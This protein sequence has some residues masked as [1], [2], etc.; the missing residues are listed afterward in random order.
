MKLGEKRT[1]VKDVLLAIKSILLASS[2]ALPR[3]LKTHGGRLM[4]L[5]AVA[6]NYNAALSRKF[7]TV[8]FSL[9]ARIGIEI[10]SWP[11]HYESWN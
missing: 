7:I 10:I 9:L 1:L 6:V 11:L 5:Y 2:Q 8:S 3:C 4:M